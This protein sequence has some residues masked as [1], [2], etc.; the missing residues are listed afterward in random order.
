M[1]IKTASI[2]FKILSLITIVGVV[3]GFQLGVIAPRQAASLGADVLQD[4]ATY[5]A[6]LLADNLSLGLQ[7]LSMD[8]GAALDQTLASIK[9]DGGDRATIEG[10]WIFGPDMRP[11]KNWS[12]NN[13]VKSA[14]AP[15][16]Q[17]VVQDQSNVLQT[18][19][20]INDSERRVLGYVEIDFSKQ[21]LKQRAGST[22][23][24]ALLI[25]LVSVGG[26]L[27]L[28]I[29]LGNRIGRP[30]SQ[31]VTIAEAVSVGDIR[32]NIN[33]SSNDEVGALADSFRRLVDY[34]K[35]LAAA[36][37]RMAANDLTVDVQPKSEADV[38]GNSFKSMTANLS[39]M[40]RRLA[41]SARE[42]GSAATEI[43]SSSEQMSQGAKNQADQVNQVSTAVEEMTAT[44]LESSRNAGEASTTAKGAANTAISGGRV[45]N[46]TIQ[47]MQNIAGVVRQSA[48]SITKLA[49]SADQ[50]GEIISVIDDIADQTN[51][52]ALNA[53][54]EAARAGEQGRGFAVVADEVRKL[55][56]RTS[57]AT[58]EITEMIKGIQR[59]TEDAV[60][61]M[62]A[63]IQ[64]VD[65][66]RTSADKAG[67]SLNEIVTMAQRVTEMIT[68]MAT[69]AEEQSSAAEQISKNIEHISSVTKE[70][71]NGARQSASAAEQLNRQADGLQQIV[72]RFKVNA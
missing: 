46:D 5:V 4:Q 56:E 35:H 45:V 19:L 55:A 72:S 36:S 22:T 7:T 50:I 51:L 25:A 34:M 28:G 59:Q 41:A 6:K 40:I 1:K 8:D 11:I 31:L 32:Q 58:G 21:F 65:K 60:N 44:I 68:Q 2:R 52:L 3:L 42:L 71:A 63:G 20:P 16:Q 49:H 67:S 37:E 14:M 61:S 53:A 27:W 54:I 23:M 43:A 12:R 13:I 10:I 29:H 70:T 30:I 57:K 39:T 24:L 9:N 62:E 26:T 15:T 47:G 48:E 33:I 66:G 64:E 69:A 17:L 18:W 38:L